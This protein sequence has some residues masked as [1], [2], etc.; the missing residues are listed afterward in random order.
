VCVV[1]CVFFQTGFLSHLLFHPRRRFLSFSY[2]ERANALPVCLCVTL[3]RSSRLSV[4]RLAIDHNL[5]GGE[6]KGGRHK[7]KEVKEE[8]PNR[9]FV[10][11]LLGGFCFHSVFFLFLF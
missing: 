4:G 5:K 9:F 3:P 7:K 11:L 10:V 6:E 1:L 2:V 8:E